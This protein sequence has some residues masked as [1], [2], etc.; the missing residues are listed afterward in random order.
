MALSD[1]N[2]A[3]KV[4]DALKAAPDKQIRKVV[5]KKI[6]EKIKKVGDRRGKKVEYKSKIMYFRVL[7]NL[8]F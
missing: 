3:D 6:V 5:A 4:V 8:S 2:G 7:L 1:K